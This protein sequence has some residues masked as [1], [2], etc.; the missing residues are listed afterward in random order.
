MFTRDDLRAL[1]LAEPAHP[2]LSVY[3]RTDPRDPANTARV[4]AWEVALRNG[5]RAVSE[6]LESGEDR[7]Q[8][9]A[10]RA[11]AARV[12]R[13]T[14]DLGPSERARSLA[15]FVDA[16][17]DFSQRLSL[18]L[19]VRRDVVVWD[20]RPFVSPLVDIADRGAATGVVLVDGE[21]VRLL[22]V[23]QGH[24]SEPEDSTY[25]L[26]LEDWRPYEAYT[27]PGAGGAHGGVSQADRFDALVEE[28]RA[29]LFDGAAV[30]TAR[31]LERLG[32]ERVVVA[33]EGSMAARF[34]SA[35]PAALRSRVAASL[36]FNPGDSGPAA[37]AAALEPLLEELWLRDSVAIA[38]LARDRVL[39]GGA[40]TLGPQDTLSALA[41][42]SVD[43]LLLDPEGDFRDVAGM[44]PASIGGPPELLGE[45]AV[46][47]A[48]SVGARVSALPAGASRAL[49]EAGGMAA[50]LRY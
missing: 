13:E 24:A 41:A 25:A 5:L 18:R 3:A 33:A 32:W 49:D 23:E 10:F 43:H 4:P 14:I 30:A 27:S 16:E 35:M 36:D 29:K 50:L 34:G 39:A 17:G 47:L 15:V 26:T 9:L 19:P 11:L 22:H 45:R 48:I 2:I 20:A 21:R 8:R 31:R 42:S 40:A 7:E 1:A 38:E 6:R 46:E 37:I 44:V 12:E 28:Q